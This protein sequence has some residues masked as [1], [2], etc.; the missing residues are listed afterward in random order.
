MTMNQLAEADAPVK[1][2]LVR[3]ATL[4]PP[5]PRSAVRGASLKLV[6]T[7]NGVGTA[8]SIVFADPV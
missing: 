1:P 3:N 5:S 7:G 8:T 2:P 6:L 4:N